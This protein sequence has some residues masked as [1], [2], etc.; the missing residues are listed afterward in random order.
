MWREPEAALRAAGRS[1]STRPPKGQFIHIYKNK[2]QFIYI[3]MYIK[4]DTDHHGHMAGV[5][6]RNFTVLGHVGRDSM[7][8]YW[9][10][11]PGSKSQEPH[12]SSF[13]IIIILILFLKSGKRWDFVKRKAH[14]ARPGRSS[15]PGSLR[16]PPSS[17]TFAPCGLPFLLI[18]QSW[19]AGKS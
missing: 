2:G 14:A 18:F 19:L 8:I 5:T 10:V 11:I 13:F 4:E 6:S 15:C 7:E 16:Q 1:L 12:L 17:I 9:S 3:Y